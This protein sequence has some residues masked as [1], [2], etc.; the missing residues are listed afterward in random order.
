M[1]D[2]DTLT[3]LVAKALDTPREKFPNGCYHE[4]KEHIAQY[5]V[6][7]GVVVLKNESAPPC[8]DCNHGWGSASV[9]G[10]KTCEESCL[11]LR[12]Y[13]NKKAVTS[14]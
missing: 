12:E 2:L 8:Q 5:L 7:N 9:E 14:K 3:Q 10:I 6:N 13:V 4:L 11:E 1:T